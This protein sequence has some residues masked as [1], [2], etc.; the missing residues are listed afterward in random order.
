MTDKTARRIHLWIDFEMTGLVPDVDNVLEAGWTL[1]DEN[2]R[3][4]TPL[5]SRLAAIAP[6]MDSATANRHMFHPLIKDGRR[7]NGFNPKQDAG[8]L[9]PVVQE[10][11]ETSGL[12]DDLAAASYGSAYHSVLRHPRDFERLLLD[13]LAAA[14]F[15]PEDGDKLVISGAGVSHFDVHV[16]ARHWPDLFPLMPGPGDAAAYYQ[17][18]TSVAWRVL[19]ESVQRL[20]NDL[21]P[22]S[23]WSVES[24]ACEAGV[25]VAVSH[26][27]TDADFDGLVFDRTAIRP[28]RAADD[29]VASLLDARLLRRVPELLDRR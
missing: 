7:H 18:D 27:V 17:H 12:F 14:D 11:H 20:V 5:R 24:V 6:E 19:G 21:G 1:T 26:L 16:L 9:A 29:V 4:I 15:R 3:M 25:E 10:M 22:A 13:D 8:L 28:H 2:L 23:A